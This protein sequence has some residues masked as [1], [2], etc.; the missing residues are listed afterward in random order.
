MV[1]Y[2]TRMNLIIFLD[3]NVLHASFILQFHYRCKNSELYHLKNKSNNMAHN[4]QA[5]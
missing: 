3:V 5:I 1:S 2:G 4:N